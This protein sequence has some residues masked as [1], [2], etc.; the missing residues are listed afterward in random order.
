MKT[1]SASYA[2]F[3]TS[4]ITSCSGHTDFEFSGSYCTVNG[5]LEKVGG[6]MESVGEV[7]AGEVCM[8]SDRSHLGSMHL[9]RESEILRGD[10]EG[11]GKVDHARPAWLQ[12][13]LRGL[14]APSLLPPL[15]SAE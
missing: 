1:C 14:P 9:A 8:C 12:G 6:S 15:R 2:A 11:R 4:L 10:G 5:K 3:M 7:K 13:M